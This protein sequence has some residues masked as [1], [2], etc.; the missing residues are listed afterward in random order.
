MLLEKNSP[1]YWNTVVTGVETVVETAP[2]AVF[3]VLAIPENM[4]YNVLQSVK[5]C[6]RYMNGAGCKGGN[7]HESYADGKVH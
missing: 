7:H 2:A 3:C 4:H 1:Q 6:R 5:V